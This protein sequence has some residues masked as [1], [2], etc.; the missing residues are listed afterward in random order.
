MKIQA[1]TTCSAA[2]WEQYGRHMAGRWAENWPVPLH[3]WFEGF[4]PDPALEGVHWS[5]LDSIGWLQQFKRD[6]AHRTPRSPYNYRLDAVRFAHKTAAVIQ[7]ALDQFDCDWLIWVDADT[8]THRPVPPEFVQSLLPQGREFLAWLDRVGNYPECGF[9]VLNLRH[10]AMPERLATW[11][12]WYVTGRLFQLREW[13]D[14]FVLQQLVE[15]AGLGTKSLSG[16]RARRTSHPFVNGPLGA[17]MDHLKG[18]RKVEGK[19][20]RGDLKVRRTEDYWKD[21]R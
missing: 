21:F 19:S 2:G 8:V 5:D 18:S 11:R 17:Y 4:P 7:S 14:S 13:H 1:I 15:T 3:V 20:R 16:D 12:S 9:Y 10:P 6:H